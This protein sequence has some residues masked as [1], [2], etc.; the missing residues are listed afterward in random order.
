M[1]DESQIDIAQSFLAL[2]IEP[3]RTKPNA[4]RSHIAERYELCEDMA[5]ML[6]TTA[7]EML[8][9]LG[10]AECDVLERCLSGLT[11]DN[12]VVTP[13]E[14]VWVVRRLA[15]LSG[16]SQPGPDWPAP[17]APAQSL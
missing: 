13:P 14:A 2:F 9:K 10:I 16:W 4:T 1:S 8:H 11:G 3:G 12:A 7:Q 6:T 5:Q 17:L 15:E